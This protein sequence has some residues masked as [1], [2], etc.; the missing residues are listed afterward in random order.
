MS[1][2]RLSTSALAR[3]VRPFAAVVSPY[4]LTTREPAALVTMQL[5][6]HAVTL[7]LAP[8]SA[9]DGS[10]VEMASVMAEARRSPV[11]VR[12]M[13][14]WEW[15]EELFR[16]GV[17]GS[18]YDGEDPV[19]DVRDA[20]VRLGGDRESRC[21]LPARGPLREAARARAERSP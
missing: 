21:P 10:G 8:P 2:E 5:A 14:S 9:R 12:Y 16:E 19:D 3:P 15:A 1:V 20:C 4:H 6:E 11:Y 17:I 18:I 7:L 13:S